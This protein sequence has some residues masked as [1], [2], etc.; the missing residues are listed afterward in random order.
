V[1][2]VVLAAGSGRRLGPLSAAVP[3]PMLAV[4]GRPVI[5]H[6]L[7]FLARAGV[8]DVFV[9]L[10][11]RPEVLRS[12]CQDGARWGVRIT[13]A[14]E[15]RLQGTAG[16]LRSFARWLGDAPFFVAYGDNYF[17]CDAAP[18]RAFHEQR[19][20]LATIALFPKDDVTG[21]G[22]V[23]LAA[24]GRVVRFVEK[25]RPSE[26]TSRLVNGG[27]YVLSP[28]VLP[29]IPETGPCDFGYDVFPALLA[30]GKPVYGRVLD[31]AVW[32]IDTPELYQTLRRRL[33]DP[34]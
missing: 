29:L 8:R 6:L 21:S 13:Y 32:P 3:K 22:V 26:T 1:K 27:L 30:A 20:G 2:A 7:A 34:A 9:N 16:A 25:P 10:H 14:V 15:A 33:G 19:R 18:L 31:G 11:H 24:D 12:Y 23:E 28:A 5:A 4:G 17:E